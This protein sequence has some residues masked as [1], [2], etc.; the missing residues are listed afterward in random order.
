MRRPAD[1]METQ[2]PDKEPGKPGPL[3]KRGA[4]PPVPALPK[5]PQAGGPVKGGS[6][7]VSQK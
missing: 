3:N 4:T 1:L 7:K 5:G 6:K 2:L